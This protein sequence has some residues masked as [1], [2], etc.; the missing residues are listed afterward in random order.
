[1][2][3]EKHVNTKIS[4]CVHG[5]FLCPASPPD[6]HD[7]FC[8]GLSVGVRK[9]ILYSWKRINT[10][11]TLWLYYH[12]PPTHPTSHS[13]LICLLKWNRVKYLLK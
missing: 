8:R 11:I 12:Q 4:S 3:R 10:Q 6:A 5:P 9:I 13:L 1:M 7:I 2:D